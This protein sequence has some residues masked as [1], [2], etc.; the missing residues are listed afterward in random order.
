MLTELTQLIVSLINGLIYR[1]HTKFRGINFRA[2]AGNEFRGSI[3][4]W[5]HGAREAKSTSSYVA[6]QEM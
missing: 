5:T 3:F 2:L 4:S 1:T 6:I